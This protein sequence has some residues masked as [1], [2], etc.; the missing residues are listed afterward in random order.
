[1]PSDVE[2]LKDI[3][4]NDWE[5]CANSQANES[6]RSQKSDL[7]APGFLYKARSSVNA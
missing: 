7:D 5:G 3:R 6:N 4:T 1:M 2:V